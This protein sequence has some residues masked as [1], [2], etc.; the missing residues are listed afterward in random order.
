M[1]L[2]TFMS[3]FGEEDHYVAAV[4]ARILSI[5]PGLQIMDISHRIAPFDIAHG[6]FV[7]KSVFRDFPQGTVH[8]VAVDAAGTP[9]GKYIILKLKDHLFVGADNGLLSLISDETPA[10][11][12]EIDLPEPVNPVFPARDILGPVAANLASGKN[13]NDLGKYTEDYKKL[14]GRQIKATKKQINGNV[15][16]VDSFGNLI[17]NIEKKIFDVLHND[18][19]FIVKFSRETVSRIHTGYPSVE[20]G[21]CVVLFNSL[22]LLEIGINKGN[23]SELIGLGYDSPV[24]INFIEN[25]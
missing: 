25:E 6:A 10:L 23:A 9:A 5:N 12:S 24:T 15:I 14:L 17:T 13:V 3:D 16:R 18:R 11:V 19:P 1:A 20:P 2:I 8:L 4:K 7:L 22:D 21:E